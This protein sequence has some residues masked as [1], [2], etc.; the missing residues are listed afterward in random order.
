[1]AGKS[2]PTVAGVCP[3]RAGPMCRYPADSGLIWLVPGIYGSERGRGRPGRHP[4][5]A[6]HSFWVGWLVYPAPCR[7]RI[8]QGPQRA[9][10]AYLP[11]WLAC[12][13]SG[14]PLVLELVPAND[15]GDI[16]YRTVSCRFRARCEK[17]QI[18][19]ITPWWCRR[20]TPPAPDVLLS[21]LRRAWSQACAVS[22]W[23]YQLASRSSWRTHV[24]NTG[25]QAVR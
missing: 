2:W 24:G 19:I 17:G 23:A 9:V 11:A 15:G 18:T 5:N 20:W 8:S 6:S 14:L 10:W 7:F 1:M 16:N 22:V 4:K 25:S 13:M 21:S 12:A 3:A